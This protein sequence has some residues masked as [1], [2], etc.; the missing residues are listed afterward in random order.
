MLIRTSDHN[1][2]KSFIGKLY[3]PPKDSHK[4]QN[5]R[6]LIVG[7]SS[8]FHSA[9]LWSAEIASHFVDIVHYSSTVENEKIFLGLK[10]TFRNGIVVAQK[11]LLDYVKEDD[12]I[13]V[14][15]G[16]LRAFQISNIKTQNLSFEELIKIKNEG[17]YTYQLTRYLIENFPEK[18]FVFD[19]GSIQM[20]DKE[21]L[22]KLK[23]K[24]VVTPHQKEFERLF[25]I[26]I[27]KQSLGEKEQTVKETAKKYRCI[28]LLKATVDIISDGVETYIIEGGNSGLTKGGTGD[29][30]AGLVLALSAKNSS[31]MAAATASYFLKKSGEALFIKK[32][33]WYNISDL[34]SVIPEVINNEINKII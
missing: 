9:S 14:G 24:P 3:L 25:G 26:A 13:L 20:M 30:L 34:I 15:P 29:L 19:A 18:R 21:W 10:K 11:D 7:G 1:S 2:I 8:L 32:G 23:T 17:E 4:G 22:L 12:A 28:I 6:V 5:G 33:C 16:M 27:E 31:L